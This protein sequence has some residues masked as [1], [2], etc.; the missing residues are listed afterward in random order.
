M[1][2]RSPA[3]RLAPHFT[4]RAKRKRN[5]GRGKVDAA[6]AKRIWAGKSSAEVVAA[7]FAG[8]SYEAAA[9]I[10]G[11]TEVAVARR[12]QRLRKAG[13]VV[14][15][16]G[17]VP[18]SPY[19]VKG[20]S[21]LR[22]AEGEVKLQWEKSSL[23]FDKARLIN[24]AA[25]A[26]AK[27]ELPKLAPAAYAG[28]SRSRRELATVY[29]ITDAH[30][31]MYA[32][33]PE[34]GAPWD[35]AVAERTIANAFADLIDRSPPARTGIVSQLGDFLHF[36]GL[37]PVTPT[38]GHLLD[39]AGRYPEVVR[40]AVRILRRAV[41]R[42]LERHR[43]VVLVI[44]EGNHDLASS[45]WLREI[46]ATLYDAEPRIEVVRGDRP[47]SAYRHGRTMLGWHHGHAVKPRD[48]PA[49]F[50]DAHAEIWGATRYRY[51]H[52]GHRH[53]VDEKEYRGAIVV[54]HPALAG[55]DAHAARGGYSSRPRAT[56]I[57]YHAEVG[58]VCR[59][60]TAPEMLARRPGGAVAK[61]AA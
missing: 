15:P 25:L 31:G 28:P 8:G 33:E 17:H 37:A 1:T 54:Q 4:E 48:L 53:H 52:C 14:T 40:M 38:S 39:A 21:T 20:V 26:A 50:A 11:M 7:F 35:L 45:V 5:K 46:F 59:T 49:L 34:T 9:D 55:A 32:A 36:D 42:A 43:R 3:E 51:F 58:E 18:E 41:D 27:A 57:T 29:T 61:R 56:A 60:I 2:R 12:I 10:L 24:E 19:V 22:D 23:D 16:Q 47:W 6:A 30:V 44:S 13:A